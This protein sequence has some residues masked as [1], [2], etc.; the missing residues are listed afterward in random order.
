MQ[1]YLG[2]GGY[3]TVLRMRWICNC[4]RDEVDM[5]LY[6]GWD[7]YA[8]VLGV[9]WI[10]NC[11]WM[12]W[13]C[14]CTRSKVN[15]ELSS[16]WGGYATFNYTQDEID[17]H[18]CVSGTEQNTYRPLSV[19]NIKHHHGITP[20]R[21]RKPTMSQCAMRENSGEH[22]DVLPSSILQDQIKLK[23]IISMKNSWGV[24]VKRCI[25]SRQV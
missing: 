25:K 3:A 20:Y 15:M 18:Q 8:T 13:I 16:G 23:N 5:Q 4:T 10:C 17:I 9:R 6:S 19:S 21:C 11:I 1:L 22:D 12:R 24:G 14:N 7:G 2:W